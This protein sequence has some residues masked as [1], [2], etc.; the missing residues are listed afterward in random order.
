MIWVDGDISCKN[1]QDRVL[2]ETMVRIGNQK[3]I[4]YTSNTRRSFW[5]VVMFIGASA[6]TR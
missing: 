2:V 5:N 3:G 6:R 4:Y 1:F